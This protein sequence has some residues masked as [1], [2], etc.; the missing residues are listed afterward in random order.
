MNIM[1]SFEKDRNKSK[2]LLIDVGLSMM[3]YKIESKT[4]PVDRK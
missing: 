1:I 4:S 2:K 3:C